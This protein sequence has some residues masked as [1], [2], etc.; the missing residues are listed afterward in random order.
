MEDHLD[1]EILIRSEE[2]L[3]T[4][5]NRLVRFCPIQGTLTPR[6]SFE[7]WYL[8]GIDSLFARQIVES[9]LRRAV[10]SPLIQTLLSSPLISQGVLKFQIFE[11]HLS[12][13]FIQA[14]LNAFIAD[15]LELVMDEISDLFKDRKELTEEIKLSLARPVFEK[16]FPTSHDLGYKHLR[17]KQTARTFEGILSEKELETRVENAFAEFVKQRHAEMRSLIQRSKQVQGV[18]QLRSELEL[19]DQQLVDLGWEAQAKVFNE[20][21][22][23]KMEL[24][25]R[26]ISS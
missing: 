24:L 16:E 10:S 18:S 8:E 2:K 11:P 5:L 25:V 13:P 15:S 22:I 1:R 21:A 6:I 3:N 4:A 23:P 9:A 19:I 20:L 26:Q 17:D 12:L 14:T 7:A